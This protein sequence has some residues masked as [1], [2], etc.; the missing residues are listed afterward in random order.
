MLDIGDGMKRNVGKGISVR[1]GM[2]KERIVRDA[3]IRNV[4][5]LDFKSRISEHPGDVMTI[6]SRDVVT[7]P[8]TMTIIGT[9]KTMIKHGFRRIPIADP[10]T[11]RLLG[12]VTSV[13]IVDFLGGGL[14]NNLIK[15]RFDGNILAAVNEGIREI[16]EENV[17]Y[18]QESDSMKDALNT[19]L[20]QNIG[21]LPIVDGEKRVKGIVSER[22]F[23]WMMTDT[24]TNK[25]VSEYMST[26]LVTAPQDMTVG[27]AAKTM[28]SNGFRRLPVLKEGVLI[29]I[30]TASDIMRF[31]GEG[32]VFEKL[33]TGNI[34][35]VFD[36]PIRELIK[37][38]VVWSKSG[39]DLGEAAGI[40]VRKNVGS[41]PIID[42]GVLKGIITERDFLRALI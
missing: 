10:G 23:V 26:K 37:R 1:D 40:M 22:D 9:V 13:D 8:P 7:V 27:D 19:M 34:K 15:N 12:I 14:R 24:I 32:E 20:S 41:L 4:G 25:R 21:G 30:L 38:E 18:L 28:I 16:M 2:N 33:V 39:I 11:N 29:G 36:V 17:I 31:L 6:A 3:Y 5:P 35:E 42:N